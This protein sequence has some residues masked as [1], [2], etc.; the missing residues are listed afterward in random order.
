MI[1][2]N[3]EENPKGNVP[4]VLVKILFQYLSEED[5]TCFGRGVYVN[6]HFLVCVKY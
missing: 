6:A 3:G 5:L 4:V 1:G 2:G